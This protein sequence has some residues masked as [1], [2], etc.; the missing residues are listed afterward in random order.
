MVLSRWL[1]R[2]VAAVLIAMAATIP[3]GCRTPSLETSSATDASRTDWQSV[4]PESTASLETNNRAHTSRRY[5]QSVPVNSTEA[6][7]LRLVSHKQPA[8]S[9]D[10]SLEEPTSD[11]SPPEELPSLGPGTPRL[12]PRQAQADGETYP[13]DLAN[14]LRLAGAN[15][16]R[17]RL[18]RERVVEAQAGLDRA[19]LVWL[20]SLR[21]GIGYNKHDGRIQATEG[22]I[23]EAGRN[24]LFVGGGAGLGAFP[25]SGAASGPA[26]LFIDFSLA[27]AAFE[28]LMARQLLQAQAA[29]RNADVNETLQNVAVAYFDVVEAHGLLVN[30]LVGI[31][32]SEQMVELTELFAREGRGEQSEVARATTELAAWR[33]AELDA[34]RLVRARSAELARLL[35]LEPSLI[36]LPLED[37]VV[38]VELVGEELPTDA[39]LAQGLVSRPEL[40]EQQALV[41]AALAQLDQE[42]WRPWLP[43][44]AVGASA[45]TFGGGTSAEF[46]NQGSRSDVDVV[47]TWELRNLGFG[48]GALRRGRASQTRQA[49]LQAAAVRDRIMAEIVTAASD[50]AAYRRQID[51]AQAAIDASGEAYRLSLIRIREGEGLPIELQQAIRAHADALNAYT[52]AVSNYNR[53]QARLVRA[54]GEPPAP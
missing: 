46:D 52:R 54:L 28:P 16:L 51:I 23:I 39:L 5:W 37:R 27:D 31:A 40:A 49:R 34:R 1:N 4:P 20:P 32:T 29:A 8:E 25:L 43:N 30:A 13:I 15:N 50:V 26:R 6:T 24:S 41:R 48:N 14:A 9:T 36:L 38:P 3:G 42:L 12:A 7:P 2:R 18:A 45:G 11:L 10:G 21:A 33:Q 22:E 17:I 53:A 19:R 44:L 35:R 47:A